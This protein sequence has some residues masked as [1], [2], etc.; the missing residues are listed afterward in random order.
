MDLPLL[1]PPLPPLSM[2]LR[3]PRAPMFDRIPSLIFDV[4]TTGYNYFFI[5]LFLFD[6]EQWHWSSSA[7]Q[8][9]FVNSLHSIAIKMFYTHKRK[10]QS[11]KRN[12]QCLCSLTLLECKNFRRHSIMHH[13]ATRQHTHLQIATIRR[14]KHNVYVTVRPSFL[15]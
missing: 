12:N 6:A 5:G 13:C 14:E 8:C 1:P 2:H 4:V 3:R 15:R 10:R 11:I 9:A 7:R